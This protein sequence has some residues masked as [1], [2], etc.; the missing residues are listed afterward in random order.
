MFG[1]SPSANTLDPDDGDLKVCVYDL[2]IVCVIVCSYCLCY[3]LY[4]LSMFIV[5]VNCLCLLSV[6]IVCFIVCFIVYVY[7]LCLLSM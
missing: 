3:C 5:Y 2:F 4:L 7:C 6:F 1:S